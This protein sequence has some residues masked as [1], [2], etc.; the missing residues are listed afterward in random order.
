MFKMILIGTTLAALVLSG[1]ASAQEQ[2]AVQLPDVQTVQRTQELLR[3]AEHRNYY[4]YYDAFGTPMFGG[5]AANAQ[6]QAAV[7]LPE[8]RSDWRWPEPT[9]QKADAQHYDAFGLPISV[10]ESTLVAQEM[11]AS[12]LAA[13]A[14][15]PR[16][17]AEGEAQIP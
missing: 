11:F 15:D 13:N 3:R 9:W 5:L 12:G 7:Q 10:P 17:L 2:A 8:M 6:Q 1:T 4:N 16:P 14:E